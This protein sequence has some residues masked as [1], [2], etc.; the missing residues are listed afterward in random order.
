MQEEL[1]IQCKVDFLDFSDKGVS[2]RK[3]AR[4]FALAKSAVGSININKSV[5]LK[6]WKENCSNENKY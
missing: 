6:A 5:I 2:Q 4:Q 1:N 3:I